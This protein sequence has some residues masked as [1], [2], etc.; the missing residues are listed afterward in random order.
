VET[1][2][3]EMSIGALILFHYVLAHGG[4]F[5]E[6]WTIFSL[7]IYLNQNQRNLE[8]LGALLEFLESS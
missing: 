6:Y 7:Q 1:S 4:E 5:I 8:N 2:S 3:N